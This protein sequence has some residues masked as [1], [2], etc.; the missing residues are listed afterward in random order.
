M[1][2]IM[3]VDKDENILKHVKESLHG[4]EF[5]VITVENSRTAIEM[6]ENDKEDKYGLILIDTSLPD[7]KMPAFFSMKPQSRMNLD[8]SK[9]E[10]F[11]QK[12]FTKEQLIEF[13]KKKL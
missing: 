12:P 13:V 9:S 7:T 10:D 1:K 8:T 3:V 2:T 5:D 6:I 4:D 11:L